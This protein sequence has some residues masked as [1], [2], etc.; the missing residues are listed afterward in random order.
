MVRNSIS[1]MDK[2]RYEKIFKKLDVNSDGRIDIR[3]LRDELG[4]S[5]NYAQ[6]KTSYHSLIDKA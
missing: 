1:E 4:I 2:E 3:D 6:V 5:E